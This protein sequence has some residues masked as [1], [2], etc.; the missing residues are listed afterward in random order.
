MESNDSTL[1]LVLA[2]AVVVGYFVVSKI[3]DFFVK[4]STWEPPEGNAPPDGGP[5]EKIG[6]HDPTKP[7]G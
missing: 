7:I 1:W 5:P 3:V 2:G 6:G 4:G